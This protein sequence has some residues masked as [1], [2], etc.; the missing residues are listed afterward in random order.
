MTLMEQII[1]IL[2]GISYQRYP[3]NQR[4]LREIFFEKRSLRFN[5]KTSWQNNPNLR[6][7]Q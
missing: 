5:K 2:T 1:Q 3:L 6:P 7:R 4:N